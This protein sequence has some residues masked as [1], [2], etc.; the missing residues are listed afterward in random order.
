[1]ENANLR[2]QEDGGYL[3]IP[4]SY[5]ENF[6]VYNISYKANYWIGFYQDRE[7][8]DYIEPLEGWQWVEDGI[9]ATGTTI[10]GDITINS[11]GSFTYIPDANFFGENTF[12]YFAYDGIQ[13]SDTT[14]V[15][16]IVNS[17]EMT[18]IAI[19]DYYTIL[20]DDT[21]EAISWFS[22]TA[23]STG[24]VVHYPLTEILATMDLME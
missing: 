15:K 4:N 14:Q 1:M 11:D 3:F 18:T 22:L 24:M 17:V 10:N 20:E 7:A 21:L 19:K 5:A 16:I 12:K 6:N 23:P 2:A 13:Y 8:S 9:V